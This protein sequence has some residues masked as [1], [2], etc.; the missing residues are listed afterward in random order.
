LPGVFPQ[1]GSEGKILAG[2][3]RFQESAHPSKMFPKA[4]PQSK[5]P[6]RE[7]FASDSTIMAHRTFTDL[8]GNVWEVWQVTPTSVKNA[9]GELRGAVEPGY[10]HGWLCFENKSGD[11][12][13]LLKIPADWDKLPESQLD[14]LRQTAKKV[15]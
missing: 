7:G 9:A 3:A 4:I 12:R 1:R 11:K 10:E 5:G 8:D 2:S 6:A 13:R 15:K 14:E